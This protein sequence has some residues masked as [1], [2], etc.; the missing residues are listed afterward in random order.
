MRDYG[1]FTISPFGEQA[2]TNGQSPA[3][4]VTLKKGETYRL[5]Y[6]IYIHPG[7]TASAKV[8]DVYARW[9]KP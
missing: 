2:Y 8:A 9:I 3:K 5:R 1:L 4:P 6:A 7:D